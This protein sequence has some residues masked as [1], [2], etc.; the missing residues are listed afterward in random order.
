MKKK[1][2]TINFRLMIFYFATFAIGVIAISLMSNSLIHDDPVMAWPLYLGVSLFGAV[3]IPGIVGM[4]VLLRKHL[5]L[6]DVLKHGTETVGKFLDVGETVGWGGIPSG[7][8]SGG[9]RPGRTVYFSQ[10]IFTYTVDSGKREYTS[11]AVYRDKQVEK[12]RELE[13]FPVKYKGR[14]AIICEIV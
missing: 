4:L 3:T 8:G 1:V 10:V 2:K 14:H 11:C 13:T 9:R 7:L 6:K 5:I 12:L